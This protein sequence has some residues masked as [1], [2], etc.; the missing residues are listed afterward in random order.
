[1]K[2]IR[3]Y[4]SAFSNALLEAV[5]AS[6]ACSSADTLPIL[7]W[8]PRRRRRDPHLLRLIEMIG[9]NT[10]LYEKT[11]QILRN[12]HVRHQQLIG[13]SAT[14]RV[15]LSSSEMPNKPSGKRK[16][17]SPAQPAHQVF[18]PPA[19]LPTM[20]SLAASV[21][22]TLRFDLLMGLN[23]AKSEAL[24]Q[25]DKIHRFVWGMDACIR[26][27]EIDRR[28]AKDLVTSFGG[29]QSRSNSGRRPST[30][31]LV[32]EVGLDQDTS[33]DWAP[34]AEEKGSRKKSTRSAPKS[35]DKRLF[36]EVDS[37][38]ETAKTT[39]Q[40]NR[41]LKMLV[42]PACFIFGLEIFK[43]SAVTL[44]LYLQFVQLF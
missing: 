28:H 32:G 4:Q 6:V 42:S 23:E 10:V 8:A 1:M 31:A 38:S 36:S 2:I 25:S 3:S 29:Y 22:C 13:K 43:W 41:K 12:E 33:E 27:K 20:Q 35:G 26:N 39:D 34:D 30:S 15:T 21:L 14:R 11:L 16:E 18:I 40:E 7:F 44:G 5:L 24:F 9:D 19:L 17:E 37:D